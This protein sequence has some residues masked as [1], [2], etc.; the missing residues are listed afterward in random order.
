MEIARKSP[1]KFLLTEEQINSY[2]KIVLLSNIYH[3]NKSFIVGCEGSDNRLNDWFI[4]LLSENLIQQIHT[5]N[6]NY[7]DLSNQAKKY[8]LNLQKRNDEFNKIYQLYKHIDL[9]LGIFAHEKF[10]ELN[11]HYDSQEWFDY[12]ETDRWTDLRCAIAYYKGLEPF[13]CIFLNMIWEQ[14]SFIKLNNEEDLSIQILN[15]FSDLEKIINEQWLWEET[16]GRIKNETP[17][18]QEEI[19]YADDVIQNIIKKGNDI[20]KKLIQTETEINKEIEDNNRNVNNNYQPNSE[21]QTTEEIIEEEM[22]EETIT[23]TNY[24]DEY[25]NDPYYVSPLW[26]TPVAVGLVAFAII[27]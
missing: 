27:Y 13:D 22:I 4:S 18:N 9:E 20:F 6:V 8:L 25:Y 24:I 12:I 7:Y 19:E 1:N 23:E 2:G 17:F 14:E 10:F 21:I 5:E 16:C 3:D 15:V 11:G 26:V